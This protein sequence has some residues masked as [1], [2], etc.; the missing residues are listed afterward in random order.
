MIRP[1][2][3]T[4]V[5]I[6]MLSACRNNPFQFTEDGID[7]RI[8]EDKIQIE[9]LENR[10]L[11]YFTVNRSLLP[12]IIWIPESTDDNRI[13]PFQRK[14]FVITEIL[15]YS[16]FMEE[17]SFFYWRSEDPEPGEAVQIVLELKK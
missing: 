16:E 13:G 6:L 7:F 1:L 10:N 3:F 15:G 5:C 11:Y 12:V 2:I 8:T 17:V 14:E 4:L 9:N